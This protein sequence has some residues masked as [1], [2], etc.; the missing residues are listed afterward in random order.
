MRTLAGNQQSFVRNKDR[1]S[2]IHWSLGSEFSATQ[3]SHHQ[4]MRQHHL[5]VRP[6]IAFGMPFGILCAVFHR[7]TPRLSFGPIDDVI[8]RCV[9]ESSPFH[10]RLDE[11]LQHSG[12]RRVSM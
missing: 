12:E 10:V 1:G 4:C 8:Q 11:K 6:D 9:F 7:L 2:A 5:R 3:G